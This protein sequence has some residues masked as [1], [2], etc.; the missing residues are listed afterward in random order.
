[1]SLDAESQED[2]LLALSSIYEESFTSI[3]AEAEVELDGSSTSHGGVLAIHL[4]LPPDFTLLSRPT[5]NTG[6]GVMRHEY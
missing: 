5:K 2:E 3:Q 1:M 4:D 6:K